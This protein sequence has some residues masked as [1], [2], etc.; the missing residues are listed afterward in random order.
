MIGRRFSYRDAPDAYQFIAQ[1]PNATI[2]T[3]LIYE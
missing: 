1:H 2:K 3:L